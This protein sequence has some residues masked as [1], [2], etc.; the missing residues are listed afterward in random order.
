MVDSIV[1]PLNTSQ[2]ALELDDYL[3][4]YVTHLVVWDT[5]INLYYSGSVES[6]TSSLSPPPDLSHLRK[7]IK[8]LQKTSV[9]LDEEKV[10]AEK[11]FKELL[12]KVRRIIDDCPRWSRRG[13]G[14]YT[15]AKAWFQDLL[16]LKGPDNGLHVPMGK[17][18]HH[19]HHFDLLIGDVFSDNPVSEDMLKDSV[20]SHTPVDLEKKFP[21]H[22]F[23]RAA[24]RLRKVNK[25]LATFEQGFIS[26]EGIKDR[27]WYKHLVVAP[28]KN[29]GKLTFGYSGVLG[30]LLII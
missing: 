28:G 26:K 7:S 9:E 27:E 24:R 6:L 13:T 4:V 17:P 10:E 1:L 23:I 19:D 14:W 2:Y 22:K 12:E 5:L 25:K 21:I 30:I 18:S 16:G 29:L 11:K 3:D 20:F 8:H 15:N